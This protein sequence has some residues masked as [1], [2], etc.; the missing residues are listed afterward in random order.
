MP[1]ASQTDMTRRFGEAE[2]IQLTD[3]QGVG[4]IDTQVLGDALNSA[5]AEIHAYIAGRY[6]V[7][8]PA[9]PPIIVQIACDI[10]RYRLW[11]DRASDEVRRRY[12]D[13]RAL[14]DRIARGLAVLPLP[15]QQ[16]PAPYAEARPGSAVFRRDDTGF[17]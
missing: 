13:A 11:A 12:E 14:L 4:A 2:L 17:F 6:P 10:A 1:Y 7:P 8:L 3:R 9:V 5:D 15:P 16:T